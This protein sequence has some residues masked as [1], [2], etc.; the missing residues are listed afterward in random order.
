M[1]TTLH[2]QLKALYGLDETD[3]EVSVDGYRIDAVRAGT[4]IEVQAASL[5]AIR[6]KVADLLDR[7]MVLVVKP[8]AVNTLI[9]RRQ[10]PL[11][12]A[13]GARRSPT[14]HHVCEFFLDFVH[15]AKIF[16]HPN[17]TMELLLIDQEEVRIDRR[18]RRR[19]RNFRVADRLLARVRERR[20]LRTAKDLCQF[21]PEGLPAKFTTAE[22]AQQAGISRWLAQKVAYSLRWAGAIS[23]TG[24]VRNSVVYEV[25]RTRKQA[26]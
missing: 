3:R 5:S 23:T 25:A 18:W 7:H 21:L 16:P 10:S 20:V 19:G 17:L 22:L 24:K 26:A 12:H 14:T 6:R 9:T 2:R 8:L 11:G 15:F 4:L 13:G 1:E